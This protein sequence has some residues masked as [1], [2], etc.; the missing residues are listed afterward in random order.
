MDLRSQ[1]IIQVRSVRAWFCV[2]G[3]GLGGKGELPICFKEGLLGPDFKGHDKIPLW[4]PM[5]IK[6][7]ALLGGVSWG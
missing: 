1:L 7:T 6:S 3:K 5:S 4:K 2:I